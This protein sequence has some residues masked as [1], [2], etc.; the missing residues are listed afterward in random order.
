MQAAVPTANRRDFGV[1]EAAGG[2]TADA[3]GKAIARHDGRKLSNLVTRAIPGRA[4]PA[5]A[6]HKSD[7]TITSAKWIGSSVRIGSSESP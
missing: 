1:A 4:V 3:M 2:P 7:Q 6:K 5:L